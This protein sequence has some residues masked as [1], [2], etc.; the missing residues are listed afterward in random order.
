MVST[1][2]DG[3]GD[4]GRDDVVRGSGYE[5]EGFSTSL[6][7]RMFASPFGILLLGLMQFI[8]APMSFVVCVM[9]FCTN[10]PEAVMHYAI[11]F[12][13]GGSFAYFKTHIL[14]KES[15]IVQFDDCDF[16]CL[17]ITWHFLLIFLGVDFVLNLIVY[18]SVSENFGFFRLLK[19]IT[20]GTFNTKMYYIVVLGCLAISP[21]DSNS[22]V[23]AASS[24]EGGLRISFIVLL[25]TGFCSY[26]AQNYDLLPKILRFLG[27]PCF[28]A[29]FYVEHRIGHLPGVYGQAHKMHHYLHDTTAFD[30]HIYGSGMNEEFF[31]IVAEVL[32]CLLFG[33]YNQRVPSRPNFNLFPYFLNLT[34]LNSSWQNKGSHSRSSED[35]GGNFGD[36]DT[37]NFHAD[38][39]TLHMTNFGLSS[40]LCLDMYFGT[41]HP[42]TKGVNGQRYR[43]EE[44]KS[45]DGDFAWLYVEDCPFGESNRMKSASGSS[46]GKKL[47][48]KDE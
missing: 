38:H 16:G 3:H 24:R 17:S 26:V 25:L 7:F 44:P 35:K 15:L 8:V 4:S 39:H 21:G 27:L 40:S 1:S 33:R 22:D 46:S 43:L 14:S 6:I 2:S 9:R 19:H 32:P 11:N 23:S 45:G 31:W 10:G 47:G 5:S 42:A 13:V 41:L 28:A 18:L 36:Y 37:D 48:M 20:Y 34:T 30:A 12:I 29:L